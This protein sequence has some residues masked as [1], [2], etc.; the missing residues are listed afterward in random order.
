MKSAASPRLPDGIPSWARGGAFTGQW[1][2]VVVSEAIKPSD[3]V[4]ATRQASLADPRD[5][6]APGSGSSVV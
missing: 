3:A 5:D 1:D 6:G 4:R 2:T